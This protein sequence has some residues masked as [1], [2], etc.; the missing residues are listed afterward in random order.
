MNA[1]ARLGAFVLIALITL[2]L[3][4]SRIGRF[5]WVDQ[6][7]TIIETS[8]QDAAGIAVQSPVLMAGVKVG[9][10]Q[11]ITLK[12]NQALV[13]MLIL[14]AIELPAST[15]AHIA[16]GGLVGE[17]YIA[18]KARVGDAEPLKKRHIPSEQQAGLDSLLNDASS[19]SNKLQIVI[20]KA[21]HIADVAASILDENKQDLHDGTQ[22]LSDAGRQLSALLE[23]HR[24]DLKQLFKTLPRAAKSGERFFSESTQ[25][26][27]DFR[28]LVIDNRENLYR[29]LFELRKASENLAAFSDDIRRN[30]WKLLNEK[31]EVKASRHAQQI[32]M[33]EM[34][35]TTGQLG[36]SSEAP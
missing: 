30:P 36:V 22:A 6:Q 14:P 15:R 32:K 13:H 27:Q 28:G 18:L 35:L 16:G 21:D 8:L 1:Q 23:E 7:G 33:E 24:E 10:V 29:T 20:Q 9:I 3:L 31:P 4:S 2:G 25:A 11:G 34:L 26:L 19:I 17:K 5:Q 12:G